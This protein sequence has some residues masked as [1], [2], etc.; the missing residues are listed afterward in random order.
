MGEQASCG[1]WRA[2]RAHLAWDV[3]SLRRGLLLAIGHR[4]AR[5]HRRGRR[6]SVGHLG[7]GVAAS[8]LPGAGGSGAFRRG[9]ERRGGDRCTGERRGGERRC[10]GE[11]HCER[12]CIGERHGE[13]R[14]AREQHSL[15]AHTRYQRSRSSRGMAPHTDFEW[16][17]ASLYYLLSRAWFFTH[18]PARVRRAALHASTGRGRFTRLPH[19][20]LPRRPIV[21]ALHSCPTDGQAVSGG[22]ADARPLGGLVAR[23]PIR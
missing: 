4:G 18:L 15:T 16:R 10:I 11:L 13:R 5:M 19:F 9:G 8:W 17:R 1:P 3:E 23:S 14:A 2:Q 12:C 7:A 20:A 6:V 21:R 22:D